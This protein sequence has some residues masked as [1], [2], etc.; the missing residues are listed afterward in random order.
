VKPTKSSRAQVFIFHRLPFLAVISLGLIVSS[1]PLAH[2][3]SGLLLVANKGDQ[4][5]GLIDPEAGR[6]IGTVPEDGVTGHE[7]AASPDGKFAY[8]PIFGNSGVGK[9]GTD[10][11]IMRIINLAERKISATVD[12]GKGVRPHCVVVGAKSGRLYVTTEL[13]NSVTVIDPKTLSIIGTIPTDQP[14]SH[15]LAVTRD[16]RRGY[17]SNVGP[18]TVSV[19]DFEQKKVLAVIP[20]SKTAQRISLSVDDRWVF[21]SDQTKP[22]LAVIDTKTNDIS[23]WIPLPGIGY[24]TAPTPDGHWLV[25]A[26]S[27]AN[28]VAIVDLAKMEVA[29]VLEVPR[30]PQFSLVRPDGSE[31]Y[32]SCD[33]SKK[34][35][36]IDTKEWKVKK[37]IDAG[38]GADGLAWASSK[39]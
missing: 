37:L 29:H 33:A 25:V 26:I 39:P 10:G 3:A 13:D 18:G 30:A 11:R 6:M 16:E 2:A 14:E 28:K 8:V 20:I 15:M 17:T 22:Q 21:T 31:A 19:L 38:P 4:T 27:S 36:V 5:L 35:V 12:F 24:G 1:L 23:R 32:V 7:V 9:P 34:I